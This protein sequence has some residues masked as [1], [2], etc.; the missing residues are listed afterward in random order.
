MFEK[1]P[2]SGHRI[3]PLLMTFTKEDIKK[4]HCFLSSKYFNSNKKLPQL[5][6]ELIKFHSDYSSPK[7]NKEYLFRK[8]YGSSEFRDST[9]RSLLFE[10]FGKAVDFLYQDEL[11][12]NQDNLKHLLLKSFRERNQAYLLSKHLDGIDTDL[13][14][15]GID[16]DYFLTLYLFLNEK[17]NS[18][19]VFSKTIKQSSLTDRSEDILSSTLVLFLFFWMDTIS[20]ALRIELYKNEYN[21]KKMKNACKDLIYLVNEKK[22]S[23]L[24]KKHTKYFFIF[25]LYRRLLNTINDGKDLRLFDSYR[26]YFLENVHRLSKDE[27]CEH[28]GYL[29]NYCSEKLEDRIEDE[30]LNVSLLEIYDEYIRN[31]YYKT[32]E[33]SFMNHHLF[34]DIVLQAIKFKK[35]LYTKEFIE[36]Y[37]K[38]LHPRQRE[39][40]YH[41]SLSYY[42]FSMGNFD[43][44]FEELNKVK[45]EHFIYKYDMNI[46]KLKLHYDLG[47]VLEARDLVHSYKEFLR[48]SCF[49]SSNR[50][51]NHN[52]FLKYYC[53]L[54]NDS[55]YKDIIGV[56]Y[57]IERLR[58]EKDLMSKDWFIEKYSNILNQESIQKSKPL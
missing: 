38:H 17:I 33:T 28:Y 18:K 5:L 57:N 58:K 2:L 27:I 26:S 55:E 23:Y 21:L 8:L 49:T 10:L 6:N 48:T 44:S 7:L 19:I 13:K 54:L 40:L 30:K 4:F 22:I 16:V 50:R 42:Y 43:N 11:N 53:M 12:K 36:K 29:I 20:K 56:K 51:V 41:Y 14:S 32:S 45:Y 15:R 34:R 3:F 35:Y 24:M 52:K 9:I 25:E 1:K 47:F 46:L 37:Y 39:N 31:E